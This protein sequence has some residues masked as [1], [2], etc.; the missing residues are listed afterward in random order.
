MGIAVIP[1]IEK[2]EDFFVNGI[3]FARELMIFIAVAKKQSVFDV[4][5]AYYG[6][7]RKASLRWNNVIEMVEGMFSHDLGY[8]DYTREL[9]KVDFYGNDGVCLFKYFVQNDDPQRLFVWIILAINFIS[10]LF[11]SVSYL[12]I[13]KISHI[14]SKRVAH[15]GTNQ[16]VFRRNRKMNEKIAI[17]IATDFL[18]WVPFIVVCVLHSLEVLDATPWYSL[19]SMIILPIN[20][21]INPLLYD[22]VL[23]KSLRLPFRRLTEKM[24]LLYEAQ[25]S[26]FETS[27]RDVMELSHGEAPSHPRRLSLV[28]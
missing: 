8:D 12:I 16:E 19:F 21:V 7:M 22:D 24:S 26:R 13:G 2:F 18:C 1:L 25:R 17:I 15:A 28:A 23:T 11:I 3:K 6:R 10:F 27:E 14:S 5:E 9:K 4:I 20:S